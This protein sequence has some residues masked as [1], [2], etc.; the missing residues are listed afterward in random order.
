[1]ENKE[2]KLS[3]R[4]QELFEK[5]SSRTAASYLRRLKDIKGM[6]DGMLPFFDSL[7]RV[8]VSFEGVSDKPTVGTFCIMAPN[9][10]IYAAGAMPVRL[11]SGNYAAYILGDD[12]VPRD[13]CP[14][15]KAVEGAVSAKNIP[16]Y[17]D[18]DLFAIPITCD[19]KKKIAALLMKEKPTHIMHL[20]AMKT[21]DADIE[22]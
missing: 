3:P 18:C 5:K 9:E 4:R 17:E 2:N 8:H 15:V 12:D 7:S 11:C 1:M 21:E 20:P 10:L 22:Q 13:A 19:C 16:I 6:T 14:L